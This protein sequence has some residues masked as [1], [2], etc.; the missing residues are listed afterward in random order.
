MSS[1]RV[2]RQRVTFFPLE[3]TV[4]SSHSSDKGSN[5]DGRAKNKNLPPDQQKCVEE[6]QECAR[7][8]QEDTKREAEQ[9]LAQARDECTKTV[10]EAQRQV[11]ALYEREKKRG[12]QEGLEMAEMEASHR[13]SRELEEYTRMVQTIRQESERHFTVLRSSV[14]D[15]AAEVAEKIINMKLDESDEAFLNVITGVMTQMRQRDDIAVY[16]STEDYH[17]YF[18]ADNASV[19][20]SGKRSEAAVFEDTSLQK[21]DCVIE[22]EN[23]LIDCGVPGQIE[24]LKQVLRENRE[25][26]AT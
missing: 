22:T 5:R 10:Q 19:I 2:E 24:R 13:K 1:F 11:L 21:G 6:A 14:M 18:G 8:M 17:R 26:E 25:D 12:Y 9:L 3:E 7:K 15:L 23:E 20:P 4:V 16:V